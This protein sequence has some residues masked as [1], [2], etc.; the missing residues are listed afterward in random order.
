MSKSKRVKNYVNDKAETPIKSRR[1]VLALLGLLTFLTFFVGLGFGAYNFLQ[2]RFVKAGPLE[3]QTVF[4]V[5][6]GAGVSTIA[7]KLEK[8]ELI[9]SARMFKL[10][11]RMGG[12]DKGVK[13]GEFSIPAE[14]SLREVFDI[15]SEGKAIL[16][17]FTAP[18]GLTSAQIL[19][20]IQTVPTLLDDGPDIPAEGTLLPE[21]Y[22]TPRGMKQSELLAKMRQAQKDVLD[23]LWDTRQAGLPIKTKE[24]AIILASIVEKETGNSGERDKVAGVFI[25]RLNKGMRLESDPTIIYGISRGEILRNRAGKQRG[26][27]RSEIDR[28][29][30]W[31]TYQIDGLPKTPICNPGKEAI[32]A[33]LNPA[34]TDAIF[35]VADGTGGHVFA[36][37]LREHNRNVAEWRKIERKRKLRQ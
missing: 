29:T 4:T 30:D 32:A 33:V 22:M 36:K 6:K 13:A 14:A 35:F 28:K 18:E 16:Y 3:A 31:N 37:T 26:L 15:L 9:D 23:S 21:T 24:E 34:T 11:V 8:E 1:G 25:N 27:F 19:R 7:A 12:D 5:P 2:Y 17:P 20:S 10:M